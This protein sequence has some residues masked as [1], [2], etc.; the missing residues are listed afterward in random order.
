MLVIKFFIATFTLLLLS[1]PSLSNPL[2]PK[3]GVSLS[4]S[5]GPSASNSS[6]PVSTSTSAPVTPPPGSSGGRSTTTSRTVAVPQTA[7]IKPHL[8]VARDTSLFYSAS[9]GQPP[10]GSAKQARE[11]ARKKKNGYKILA[12]MWK[13]SNY[14]NTW[15]NDDALSKEFF[16]NASEAMAE[17]SSGTRMEKTGGL[18][19]YGLGKNGQHLKGIQM[20]LRLSV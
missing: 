17:L 15:Q 2:P 19:Q 13:D 10:D 20:L 11:W 3:H 18:D 6:P 8:A 12:Q 14:Q 1:F 4:S 5:R 9:N 7:D 16:D